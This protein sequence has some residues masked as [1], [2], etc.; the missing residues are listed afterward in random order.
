MGSNSSVLRWPW[1][2][3]GF[4]LGKVVVMALKVV[5]F[6][7]AAMVEYQSFRMAHKLGI[8][9]LV[10]SHEGWAQCVLGDELEVDFL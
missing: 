8:L 9:S 4:N 6:R 7:A 10:V 5:V 1:I 2:G 3:M